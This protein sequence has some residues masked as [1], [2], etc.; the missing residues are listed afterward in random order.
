MHAHRMF[1]FRMYDH[2]GTLHLPLLVKE[3]PF[4]TKNV[5]LKPGELPLVELKACQERD[6]VL[7]SDSGRL[8]VSKNGQ[9]RYTQRGELSYTYFV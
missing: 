2:C 3:V 8:L 5:I 9:L 7:R 6:N 1:I 4:Y